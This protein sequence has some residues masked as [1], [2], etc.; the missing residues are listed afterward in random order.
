MRRVDAPPRA[1]EEPAMTTTITTR[2]ARMH[3]ALTAAFA[4]VELSIEDESHRH[5]GHAGAR[6]EGETHYRI[7]IVSAAFTGLSRV[8]R[9]RL[10]NDA[11]APEFARGLHALALDLP[12]PGDAR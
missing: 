11:L 8:A 2:A 12:S 9:H 5:A 4:P 6:P 3:E 1:G 10:V 7:R